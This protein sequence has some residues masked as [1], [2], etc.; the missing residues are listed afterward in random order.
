MRAYA[1]HEGSWSRRIDDARGGNASTMSACRVAA[2]PQRRAHYGH[3]RASEASLD[4]RRRPR[5]RVGLALAS[6]ADLELQPESITQPDVFVVPAEYWIV[7]LDARVI[8]RW[9]P[10]SDRP[11]IHRDHLVWHP[12]ASTSSFS[13]DM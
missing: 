13:P 4:C 7:D 3:A 12:P 5:T 6:P 8:E 2:I 1:A 9:T 10:R 11:D